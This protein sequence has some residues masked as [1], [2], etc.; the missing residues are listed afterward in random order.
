MDPII[1][2]IIVAVILLAVVILIIHKLVSDKKKGK[3]TCGGC[4]GGPV[5]RMQFSSSGGVTKQD[6]EIKIKA[7]RFGA[8]LLCISKPV[9]YH[10]VNKRKSQYDHA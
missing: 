1:G 6:K 10:S 2:S 5:P 7:E 4:V 8:P 3:F 9:H